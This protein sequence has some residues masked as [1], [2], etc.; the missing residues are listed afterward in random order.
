M[1]SILIN[2]IDQTTYLNRS[3]T[4]DNIV[5]VG[6]AG[7]T[8]GKFILFRRLKDFYDKVSNSNSSDIGYK[9]AEGILRAGFPVLYK[10]MAASSLANLYDTNTLELLKDKNHYRIKFL[11]TIYDDDNENLEV[12]KNVIALAEDRGDCFVFV[13]FNEATADPTDETNYAPTLAS[14]ITDTSYA[15]VVAPASKDLDDVKMPASFW[16]LK[17]MAE[18]VSRGIPVWSIWAGAKRGVITGLKEFGDNVSMQVMKEWTEGK[19]IVPLMDIQPYGSVIYGNNTRLHT[20]ND[21][22]KS[23]LDSI[24]VRLVANEIK[25]AIYEI[26]LGLTFETNDYAL[27]NEFKLK[28]SSVLNGMKSSHGLNDFVIMMDETTVTNESI[29]ELTVPGIVKVDITRAAEKFNIDFILTPS[30]AIISENI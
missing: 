16:Y 26:C 7:D 24:N 5:V 12:V 4:N 17:T 6:G 21:A 9:Y 27:W 15:A 13:D 18:G 14:G 25:R 2:E 10:G 30:G 19:A 29:D 8:G 28:L 3:I 22:Q 11:P 1:A 20:N 23:A